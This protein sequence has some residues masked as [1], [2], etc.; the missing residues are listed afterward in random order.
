M[1]RTIIPPHH[2]HT[3]ASCHWAD[4]LTLL[5]KKSLTPLTRAIGR[6]F[7]LGQLGHPARSTFPN[8]GTTVSSYLPSFLHTDNVQVMNDTTSVAT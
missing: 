1:V 6:T 4:V 8:T 7:L 2:R 3:L 5:T